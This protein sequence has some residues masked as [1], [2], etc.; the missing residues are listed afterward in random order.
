MAGTTGNTT[1]EEEV[2]ITPVESSNINASNEKNQHTS[3][4]LKVF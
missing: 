3:I 4:N 2:M 1:I